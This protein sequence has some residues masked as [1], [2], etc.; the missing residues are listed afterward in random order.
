MSQLTKARRNSLVAMGRKITISG[1]TFSVRTLCAG[2]R[3]CTR[4]NVK[5]H[6]HD[7]DSF[8]FMKG[9]R[10]V[11]LLGQDGK[12][13][14]YRDG[15]AYRTY[16]FKA[17]GRQGQKAET[18]RLVSAASQWTDATLTDAEIDGSRRLTDYVNY[19]D[20]Q[21]IGMFCLDPVGTLLNFGTRANGDR[22]A[23]V[24]GRVTGGS[25][26]AKGSKDG[27]KGDAKGDGGSD[28]GDTSKAGTARRSHTDVSRLLNLGRAMAS[29]PKPGDSVLVARTA[30]DGRTTQTQLPAL[31]VHEIA[32][33]ARLAIV[34][35]RPS[36]RGGGRKAEY[37]SAEEA[38]EV[39]FALADQ[40]GWAAVPKDIRYPKRKP[41]QPPALP[42]READGQSTRPK[43]PRRLAPVARR[44]SA[45]RRSW[46]TGSAAGYA[47]AP[48][49]P[50]PGP[51]QPM[52][53][54][55]RMSP[56]FVSRFAAVI[57]KPALDRLAGT[58]VPTTA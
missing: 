43:A 48:E 6:V 10:V 8:R 25:R 23:Q 58:P 14:V 16:G 34:P 32:G 1:D 51:S 50:G 33:D 45:P 52:C 21:D 46:S 3:K 12:V 28:W 26:M 39:A 40:A 30:W 56:E 55:A 9:K 29:G 57:P 15:K 27:A 54:V 11:A 38:A 22:Y 24:G 20:R 2:V 49:I 35:R 19:E 53:D 36:P 47:V 4:Q 41:E 7:R 37:A 5:C 31:A 44:R 18:R 42:G 17:M 13:T